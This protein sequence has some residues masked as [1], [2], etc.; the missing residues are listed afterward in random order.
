MAA[1]DKVIPI[2]EIDAVVDDL[3]SKGA[4]VEYQRLES[5]VHGFGIGVDSTAEGWLD[6]AVAFWR[7]HMRKS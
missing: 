7:A 6:D 5:G 2:A 4:D 3:R 1:D